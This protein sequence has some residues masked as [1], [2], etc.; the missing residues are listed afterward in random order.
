MASWA[1]TQSPESTPSLRK[2][3]FPSQGLAGPRLGYGAPFPRK[4]PGRAAGAQLLVNM[5]SLAAGLV[6]QRGDPV[7]GVGLLM[8]QALRSWG[9]KV[10]QSRPPSSWGLQLGKASWRRR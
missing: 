9:H 4:G 7:L 1:A 5:A 2:P 3:T 10:V 6:T 8:S